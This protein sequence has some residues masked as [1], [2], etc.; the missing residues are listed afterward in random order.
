MHLSEIHREK[1][2]GRLGLASAPRSNV[3]DGVPYPVRLQIP[4][5]R[6]VSLVDGGMYV[7]YVLD[8]SSLPHDHPRSFHA[9]DSEG[10]IYVWGERD[11]HVLSASC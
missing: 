2:Q 6:I 7:F 4:G 1:S 11:V 5:I 9:L 8:T 10:D 3:R